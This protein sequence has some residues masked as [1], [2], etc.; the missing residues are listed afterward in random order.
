MHIHI[1]QLH[2]PHSGAVAPVSV[3]WR[4]KG[5]VSDVK[6][7]GRCVEIA[8]V[9]IA[10]TVKHI[11]RVAVSDSRFTRCMGLYRYVPQ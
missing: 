5:A 2:A 11:V 10:F 8:V 3:D 1:Y 6:D 4:K 7:Q 9:T